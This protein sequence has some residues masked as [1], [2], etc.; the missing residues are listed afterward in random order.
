MAVRIMVGNYQQ[1][2]VA[3]CYVL[4]SRAER[5]RSVLIREQPLK[6]TNCH[7]LTNSVWSFLTLIVCLSLCVHN[8][9]RTNGITCKCFYIFSVRAHDP[10]A[11]EVS[12]VF[13]VLCLTVEGISYPTGT[14]LVQHINVV[15]LS[16]LGPSW[17]SSAVCV[18]VCV[19][20]KMSVCVCLYVSAPSP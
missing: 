14:L 1:L 11:V 6:E 7:H 12:D 9:G 16:P 18:S 13:S 20:G 5:S 19:C 3:S 15:F 8:K 4:T 10:K 17:A 2:S